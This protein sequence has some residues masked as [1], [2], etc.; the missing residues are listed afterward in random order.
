V[1]DASPATTVRLAR[2]ELG[3]LKGRQ[4]A[5][6]G[7]AWHGDS[8]DARNSPSLVLAS[9][10]RDSGAEVIVHDPHVA[11]ADPQLARFGFTDHFTADMD[12][13]MSGR[14]AVFVATAHRAYRGLSQR[15]VQPGSGI[16]G[17]IDAC[18]LFSALDFPGT[19][20]VYAGIGR[21]RRAP[22]RALVR[23]V[24]AMYHA[25][26]RGVSNEL[27]SLVGFLNDRYAQDTF[28]RVDES[29]VRALAATNALGC[30]I[31]EPGAIE[32]IEPCDGFISGL[33]QLAVDAVPAPD[34]RVRI[35]P[36]RVPAGLWFGNEDALVPE[37]DTP[38]PLTPNQ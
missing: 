33:A 29:E 38:W 30:N 16:E 20:P 6:L 35:L 10:L 31:D 23:A 13:A 11:R 1:N 17:V 3:S 4:V 19:N 26:S 8:S 24:A 5:V 14:S 32:P 25:V 12:E 15:L 9:L 2:L 36:E 27:T 7:A 18:N 34:R 21:G 28:N 37:T 22:E